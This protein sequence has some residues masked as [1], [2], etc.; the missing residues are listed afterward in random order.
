[1]PSARTRLERLGRCIARN[2]PAVGAGR[3]TWNA[4]ARARSAVRTMT[5]PDSTSTRRSLRD[6]HRLLCPTPSGGRP[7][8]SELV[9]ALKG[10]RSAG[11]AIDGPLDFAQGESHLIEP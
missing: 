7:G 4:P 1:M 11:V 8:R 10:V 2:A 6:R 5:G 3:Q 9:E